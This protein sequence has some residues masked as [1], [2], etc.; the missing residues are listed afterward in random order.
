MS[1][2]KNAFDRVEF[3]S[4]LKQ[5]E[6]EN[7]S[8]VAKRANRLRAFDIGLSLDN[9]ITQAQKDEA[10]KANYQKLKQYLRISAQ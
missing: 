7:L 8:I 2:T 5:G 10:I 3:F 6:L 9:A 1:L 4:T